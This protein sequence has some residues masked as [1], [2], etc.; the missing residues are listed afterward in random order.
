MDENGEIQFLFV[1]LSL[2]LLVDFIHSYDVKYRITYT[3]QV[4]LF[5]HAYLPTS[6]FETQNN[7]HVHDYE[8]KN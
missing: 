2:H 6:L 8:N 1:F 5:I 7:N 3:V 4:F